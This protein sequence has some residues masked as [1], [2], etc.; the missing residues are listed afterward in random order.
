[1]S[2]EKMSRLLE[3]M[4]Y[5]SSGIAY[6]IE[7][8]CHRFSIS[9]RTAFR[10]ID[11]FRNV[12]FVLEANEHSNYAIDK[13][14]PF[15]KEIKELIH[16]STEELTLLHELVYGVNGNNPL[17][18][19]LLSRFNS[20]QTVLNT[21]EQNYNHAIAQNIHK[22]KQA[23]THKQQVKLLAYHSANS[24]T[25]KERIVEPF[26]FSEENDCIW[27]L[28]CDELSPKVFKVQRMGQVQVLNSLWQHTSLHQATLTDAF[29]M[30]GTQII[31]VQL[32]LNF[33]AYELLCEEHPRACKQTKKSAQGEYL[34]QDQV[35]SFEG[36][37]RFVMGLLNEV[38][39]I[40]P[41][42]LKQHIQK[43]IDKHLT[44][45]RS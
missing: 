20:L 11:T 13:D 26:C 35:Q 22:L 18:K 9:E 4:I 38:E 6:S 10:Y 7:D 27:A 12:G 3:M 24:A 31:D 28:D 15:F 30:S 17:K 40:Y 45:V 34:Y 42:K 5:L 39:I 36:I 16:F 33:R 43:K 32:K 21:A 29:G 37:S 41:Q 14:S 19:V 1:M 2:Q 25:I 8:I 23:I 44:T